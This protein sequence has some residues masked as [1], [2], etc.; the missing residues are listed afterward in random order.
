MYT[1]SNNAQTQNY[2]R[3]LVSTNNYTPSLRNRWRL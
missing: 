3:S 2:V 1:N